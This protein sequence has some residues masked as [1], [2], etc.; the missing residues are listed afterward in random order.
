M[1]Q[2]LQL[3]HN[4]LFFAYYKIIK[5]IL[6]KKEFFSWSNIELTSLKG[7][8]KFNH[9]MNFTILETSFKDVLMYENGKMRHFETISGM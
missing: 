1:A 8:F 9:S 2:T 4:I 3:A 6:K 5:K 7:F